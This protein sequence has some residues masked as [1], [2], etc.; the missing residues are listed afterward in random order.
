V[1]TEIN[2]NIPMLVFDNHDTRAWT[3]GTATA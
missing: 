3:R 2:G 1:E